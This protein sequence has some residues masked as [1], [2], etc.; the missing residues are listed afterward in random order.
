MLHSP[1]S[2][3]MTSSFQNDRL[4]QPFLKLK[5]EIIGFYSHQHFNRQIS[6][7]LRDRLSDLQK[8]KAKVFP[9]HKALHESFQSSFI[10]ETCFSLRVR[11]LFRVFKAVFPKLIRSHFGHTFDLVQAFLVTLSTCFRYKG[12]RPFPWPLQSSPLKP[13]S[14]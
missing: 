8:Y 10:L 12:S 9:E 5:V 13:V 1:S 4:S 3:V 14:R 6:C 11:N 7:H 2:L